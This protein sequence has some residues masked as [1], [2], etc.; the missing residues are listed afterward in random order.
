MGAKQEVKALEV[1]VA[2][3]EPKCCLPAALL[4]RGTDMVLGGVLQEGEVV[5][6]RPDFAAA[7]GAELKQAALPARSK[8]AVLLV[9][10]VWHKGEVLLEMPP[11]V[12][13]VLFVAVEAQLSEAS[14]EVF[15]QLLVEEVLLVACLARVVHAQVTLT[16]AALHM[17]VLQWLEEASRVVAQLQPLSQ[18]SPYVK[19]ALLL[20]GD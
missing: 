19:D 11:V 5:V 9:E 7:K 16:C 12:L 20:M 4:Q 17:G 3:M 13:V 2:A 6:L 8:K 1:A 15:E 18:Q 10:P 14:A